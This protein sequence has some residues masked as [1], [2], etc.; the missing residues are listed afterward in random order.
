ML[1]IRQ[2]F[3]KFLILFK[4]KKENKNTLTV[5]DG[6]KIIG[7]IGFDILDSDEIDILYSIPSDLSDKTPEEIANMAEQFASLLLS[8]TSGNLNETIFKS[9]RHQMTQ[10]SDSNHILFIDNI[11][12]FWSVLYKD[13]LKKRQKK[14]DQYQP[15]VRPSEVFRP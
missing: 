6:T 4:L 7:S 13:K 11:L 5:K 3:E 10:T 12:I 2:L 14:Y 1:T 8:L 15:V 9:L